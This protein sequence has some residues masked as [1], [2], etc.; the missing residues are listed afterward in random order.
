MCVPHYNLGIIRRNSDNAN[1][2]G[3]IHEAA[4]HCLSSSCNSQLFDTEFE[5]MEFLLDSKI[6][7][8]RLILW[9]QQ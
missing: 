1:F 9:R 5:N 2:V 7:A 4:L 3:K 6:Y 8:V